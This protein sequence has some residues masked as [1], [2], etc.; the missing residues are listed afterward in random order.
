[1]ILI[2]AWFLARQVLPDLPFWDLIDFSWHFYIIGTGIL[3][4][5]VGLLTGAP[6]MSVPAAL[7]SGIGALLYW[8]DMT[9]NWESWAY[10]WTLI[11][12]FV[13][14]GIILQG[15]L[16]ERQGKSLAKDLPW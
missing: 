4:F 11:P 1:M 16:G 12:G 2:G 7:V 6:S 5:L 13:G 8:Q 10:A 3:L 14:I 15:L 9:N